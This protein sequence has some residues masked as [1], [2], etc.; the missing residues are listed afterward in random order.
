LEPWLNGGIKS[1]NSEEW[2]LKKASEYRQH[3]LECH[4]M[5]GGAATLQQRALIE[6]MVR[7]WQSL[8]DERERRVALAQRH[9]QPESND[10]LGTKSR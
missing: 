10:R 1:L 2:K 5:L 6:N 4:Q 3:A 9:A 7:T 8:A